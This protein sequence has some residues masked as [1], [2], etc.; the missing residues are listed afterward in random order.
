V[1]AAA[2]TSALAAGTIA[3]TGSLVSSA[4]ANTEGAKD[5]PIVNRNLQKLQ[6]QGGEKWNPK[7]NNKDTNKLNT[8]IKKFNSSENKK[9]SGK[10]AKTAKRV[11]D[12]YSLPLPKSYI[13]FEDLPEAFSWDNVDGT[14]YL[15]HM[16][17]QHIPQY[18]GSCWAHSS[19]SSLADRIKIARSVD[20]KGGPEINLSIQFLLNCAAVAGSCF[21][22]RAAAAYEFIHS[23]S[24]FIPYDTCQPYLACSTNSTEGFCPH[25]DTTCSAINTCKTCTH[26]LEGD[27]N[28]ECVEVSNIMM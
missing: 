2:D 11:K 22:G 13:A 1:T 3:E 28:G 24:K 26:P 15:T 25:V 19:M 12:S 10:K 18:C 14:S 23:H 5:D 9:K 16:L 17:N 27:D 4:L 20:Q 8:Q 7:E 21:G 6:V